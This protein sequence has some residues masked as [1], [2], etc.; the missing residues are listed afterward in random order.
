[1]NGAFYVGAVALD[2]QQRALDA[3]SNNVANINTPSFKRSDIR[4]STVM[5]VRTTPDV[6]A[7]DLG[8]QIGVAGVMARTV[9]AID[10]PGVVERSGSSMD[11]AIEGHGFIELLGPNG[12]TYLWRGGRLK[13]GKDG[14]LET[15]VGGFPLKAL[16]NVPAD[17]SGISIATDGTVVAATPDKPGGMEV[18]RIDLVKTNDVESLVPLDGGFYRVDDVS[19]LQ[20][21][22]AASAGS[23]LFVQSGIERANVDLNGS[24]VS[25]LLVQRAYAANAQVIQAADQMAGIANGLKR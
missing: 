24:M 18:G 23:G 13:V 7:P 3:I 22:E 11:L 8:S 21:M 4:F 9:S 19:S 25:L 2:A 10:E 12:Q 6:P 20:T 1:M 15:T 5:S 14:V 17:A 16:I